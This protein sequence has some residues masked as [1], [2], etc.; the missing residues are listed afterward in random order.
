MDELSCK[1]CGICCRMPGPR[2]VAQP[3]QDLLTYVDEQGITRLWL[4]A[5]GSCFYEQDRRCT[6]YD[7]RPAE[8][9]EFD[10]REL[11]GRRHVS[12]ELRVAGQ[13]ARARSNVS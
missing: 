5:D 12:L 3:T 13:L 2:T 9:R 10:C 8:C 4:K 1:G 6:I 7:H 11:V